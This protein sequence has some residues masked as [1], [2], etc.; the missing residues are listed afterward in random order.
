MAS[1]A[2]RKIG[3]GAASRGKSGRS[4]A[5]PVLSA[6]RFLHSAAKRGGINGRIAVEHGLNLCKEMEQTLRLN[7]H[8]GQELADI[9]HVPRV[10]PLDFRQDLCIEIIMVEGDVAFRG[11]EAAPSVPTWKLRNEIGG[12]RER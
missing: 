4:S 11:D 3:G 5:R 12:R 2:V 6:D 10:A 9:L 7:K 8:P 1:S